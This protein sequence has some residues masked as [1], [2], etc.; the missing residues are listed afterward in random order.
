MAALKYM[1]GIL[2]IP[3]YPLIF[4]ELPHFFYNVDYN[5]RDQIIITK[6][7]S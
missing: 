5:I 1:I 4:R 2:T 3:G 7:R 6:I